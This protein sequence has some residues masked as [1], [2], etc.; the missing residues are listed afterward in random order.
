M[1]TWEYLTTNHPLRFLK[2]RKDFWRFLSGPLKSRGQRFDKHF[3]SVLAACYLVRS[4]YRLHDCIEKYRK[5]REKKRE[6]QVRLNEVSK[7]V[8]HSAFTAVVDERMTSLHCFLAHFQYVLNILI[9]YLLTHLWISQIFFCK[10]PCV[11]WSNVY[12]GQIHSL[13]LFMWQ[14]T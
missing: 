1:G 10:Y 14:N 3:S 5:H 8:A 13:Q 12:N 4:S 9:I 11:Q 7:R 6:P 2:A